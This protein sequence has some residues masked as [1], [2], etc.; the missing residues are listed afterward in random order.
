MPLDTEMDFSQA[1]LDEAKQEAENIIE[2]ARREAERILDGARDELEQEVQQKSPQ[3]ATQMAKTRY[4][5]LVASAEL[6]ARKQELLAQERLI[7]DVKNQVAERLIA[8]RQDAAYPALLERLILDGLDSLDGE[9]FDVLVAPE[10]REL[11]DEAFLETLQKKSTRKLVLSAD[12]VPGITGVI[13][14]RE[15]GRVQCDNSLQGLL[16]QR[17]DEI[18]RVIANTLFGPT[19]R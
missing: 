9:Y 10:D 1:V 15:D 5:Q 14:Q 19:A 13:I 8:L 6:E 16:Q 2:L 3:T 18:R 17:E 4:K 7:A 11:I 12:S